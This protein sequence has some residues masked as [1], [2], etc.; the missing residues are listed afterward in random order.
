M[1]RL[2]SRLG[3][4]THRLLQ[5]LAACIVT[6]QITMVP[7]ALLVGAKAD[8]WGRKPPRYSG[9]NARDPPLGAL[10]CCRCVTSRLLPQSTRRRD[11]GFAQR[12]AFHLPELDETAVWRRLVGIPFEDVGAGDLDVL[13]ETVF[14]ASSREW[15]R[16]CG[17]AAGL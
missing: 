16:G 5:S 13:V 1:P 8:A 12:A 15:R 6:A 10:A 2:E 4:K 7:V 17:A 9:M 11:A 14:V 3:R